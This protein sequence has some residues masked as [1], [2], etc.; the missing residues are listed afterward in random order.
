MPR[1]KGRMENPARV[2]ALRAKLGSFLDRVHRKLP[3]AQFADA[4]AMEF[5]PPKSLEHVTDPKKVFQYV[6]DKAHRAH[7]SRIASKWT[8]IESKSAFLATTD[9]IFR[10]MHFLPNEQVVSLGSGTGVIET[11]LA[12]EI[13]P[14]G[15]ITLVD[16]AEGMAKEAKRFARTEQA[17]NMRF[18]T[19]QMHRAPI[20]ANSA[21]VVMAINSLQWVKAWPKAISEMKRMLKKSPDSRIVISVHTFGEI[22]RYANWGEKELLAELKKQGFEPIRA[23]KFITKGQTDDPTMRTIIIAGLK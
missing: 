22:H 4:V 13:I 21:D 20:A 1:P 8:N 2:N 18:V 9:A 5:Q 10:N 17:E 16:S 6:P 23:T 19:G 15:K 12:K 3:A 14:K 11:F 7:W